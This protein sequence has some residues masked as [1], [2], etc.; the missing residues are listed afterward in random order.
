M[1]EVVLASGLT[2]EE[3]N[4]KYPSCC[5]CAS[6]VMRATRKAR[7]KLAWCELHHRPVEYRWHV[8]G[9][10]RFPLGDVPCDDYAYARQPSLF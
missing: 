1:P 5:T 4:Y 9:K 7:G 2:L 6:R 10:K 8:D 3:L